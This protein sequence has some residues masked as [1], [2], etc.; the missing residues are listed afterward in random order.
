VSSTKYL[1]IY[2]YQRVYRYR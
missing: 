1:Q 2:T